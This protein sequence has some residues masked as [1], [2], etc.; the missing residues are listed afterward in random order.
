MKYSF[1][2]IFTSLTKGYYNFVSDKCTMLGDYKRQP[3]AI[4]WRK[5]ISI[6]LRGV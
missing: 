5:N 4:E 3:I 1:Y 2:I 6:Y